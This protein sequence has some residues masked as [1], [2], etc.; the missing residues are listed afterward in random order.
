MFH[1]S[2]LNMP[3]AADEI[4]EEAIC[5]AAFNVTCSTPLAVQERRP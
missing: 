1:A 5:F 2:P 3:L 4:P